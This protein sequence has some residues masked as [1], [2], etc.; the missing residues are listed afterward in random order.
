MSCATRSKLPRRDAIAAGLAGLLSMAA[1]RAARAADVGR[2]ADAAA[3][4]SVPAESTEAPPLLPRDRRVP[5]GVAVLDL[6]PQAATVPR[7]EFGDRRVLVRAAAG[8]W[9]A[10]V[11]LPLDQALGTARV[12]VTQASTQQTLEFDVVDKAYA[13]QA[14]RVAPGQV[15]LSPQNEARAAREQT[16]IRAALAT[17]SEPAVTGSLELRPPLRGPRSSSFGLRRV[18]NG[19]SRNP[20]SGMDIAGPVG[21]S[22]QA[23]RAG[24]VVDTGDY[25]FNGQTVI[26][27][28]G[29]GFVTLYCH[30]SAID[31]AIGDSLA[32]GQRL[33][34]VGATGRVTGPHLHWG[35]A[36]NRVFVDPALFLARPNR[37]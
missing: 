28:H 21:A 9:Q 11:G 13:R 37:P 34:A 19:E 6:G 26:V 14:L 29:L 35:V 22:I 30:L 25:F 15:N 1:P 16:R 36:L 20:H 3:A 10:I 5:G 32:A 12:V 33:G 23:P 2:T 8:R 27:D 18:F 17:F 7:V 24:R 4:R 31:V